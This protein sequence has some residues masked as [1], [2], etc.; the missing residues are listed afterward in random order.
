MFGDELLYSKLAQSIASGHGL[1]LRGETVF[2]PAPLPI[3]AQAP[4][5]LVHSLASGYVLAKAVNVG[6]MSAAVFPAY[7]LARRLVRPSYALLAAAMTVAGPVLVYAPYL[8][9]EALAYPVFLLALATM[10]CAFERPSRVMEAAVVAVSLAAVVTRVQFVVFPSPISA[11]VAVA[12]PRPLPRPVGRRPPLPRSGAARVGRGGARHL[13]RRGD[14]E[15]RPTRRLRWGSLT[16]ALLPFAAGWLIMPG[17]ILGAALLAWRP[18]S[19][20]EAAFG[21]LAL[22]RPRSFSSRSA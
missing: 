9:S 17:A 16:G 20:G 2:F 13:C 11:A 21:L 15:L 12:P 3:L 19:E 7:A 22:H 10:V 4:A 6:V 8:M 18:R 5:W 1:V 14:P